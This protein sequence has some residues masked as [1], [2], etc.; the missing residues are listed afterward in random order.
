MVEDE[1]EGGKR[2][3][4]GVSIQLHFACV[5]TS[6]YSERRVLVQTVTCTYMSSAGDTNT[7]YMS[8]K[9]DLREARKRA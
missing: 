4:I 2:G 7:K 1:G 8:L 3:R 5:C 6:V 9:G